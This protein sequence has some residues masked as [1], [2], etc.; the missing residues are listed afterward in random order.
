MARGLALYLIGEPEQ[1]DRELER[2]H[3]LL[4][5]GDWRRDFASLAIRYWADLQVGQAFQAASTL[6]EQARRDEEKGR[7]AAALMV[8][9]ALQGSV[10]QLEEAGR[11]RRPSA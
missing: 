4:G 8:A 2:T 3:A 10:K 11:A 9:G 5:A 7:V 6:L 1:G